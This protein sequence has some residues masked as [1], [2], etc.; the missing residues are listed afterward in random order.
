MSF[1]STIGQWVFNLIAFALIT[2]T[3]SGDVG[4]IVNNIYNELIQIS[5]SL[6]LLMIGATVAYNALKNNYSDIIDIASDLFYKI[7]VWLLFTFGGLE[8][9]NYVAI[10]VDSLIY[11]IINPYLPQIVDDIAGGTT[12]LF[13]IGVLDSFVGLGFAQN[14]ATFLGDLAEALAVLTAVGILRYFVMMA[15]VT[16]IPLLSTLWIFEWTRKIADALVDV[17]IALIIAG[18]LNAIILTLFISTGTAFLFFL[19][20]F[21]IDLGSLA[22]LIGTLFVLKPH[23]SISFSPRKWSGSSSGGSGGT[24]SPPP[25]QSNPPSGNNQRQTYYM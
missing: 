16:L 2:P 4:N 3:V 12:L 10:F 13:G 20:P 8:I 15:I 21:V 23:E 14:I 18:L 7:G 25:S 1:I 24:S 19:L 6:S 9:Y 5:I 22:S 17:L 11:E